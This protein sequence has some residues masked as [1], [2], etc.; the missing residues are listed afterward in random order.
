MMGAKL[1]FMVLLL[2]V[3]SMGCRNVFASSLRIVGR[4]E[5]VFNW[6]DVNGM[7]HLE[8]EEIKR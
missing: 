6:D 2:I 8:T 3:S 5:M 7:T 1:K 4:K